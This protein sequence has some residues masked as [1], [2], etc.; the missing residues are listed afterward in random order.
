MEFYRKT[1][2]FQQQQ[3]THIKEQQLSQCLWSTSNIMSNHNKNT[4]ALIL[5]YWQQHIYYATTMELN[6]H[7]SILA[8]WKAMGIL[9]NH[10]IIISKILNPIWE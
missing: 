10:S 3:K 6:E 8:L 7:L 2:K 4:I 5:A 1:V 9:L